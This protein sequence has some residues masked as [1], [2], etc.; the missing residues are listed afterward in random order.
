MKIDQASTTFEQYEWSDENGDL[1]RYHDLPAV[2]AEGKQIWYQ[3]GKLHRA[4]VNGEDIGPAIILS[5]GTREW[6]QHGRRHRVGVPHGDGCSA[7]HSED[8]GPAV[9]DASGSQLW[10]RYGKC[11]RAGPKGEDIGPAFIGTN[12]W[13][14]WWH[15]GVHLRSEWQ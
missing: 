14:E 6:Y 4:G 1:H 8:I 3:H 2:I 11:H 5:C 9:I 15:D 13:R 10:C 7:T 12:G